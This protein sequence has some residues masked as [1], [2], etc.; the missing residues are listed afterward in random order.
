MNFEKLGQV[1]DPRESNLPKWWNSHTMA[2]TAI[3]INN[4][5]IRVYIGAWD[6]EG[7]SRITYL[8]LDPSN[9][10]N[11]LN[12]CKFLLHC[13]ITMGKLLYGKIFCFI[14]C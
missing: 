4:E 3:N 5:F 13:R 8:D 1:F 7:I 2:P 10:L 11:I 9:P 12:V 6:K 14:V